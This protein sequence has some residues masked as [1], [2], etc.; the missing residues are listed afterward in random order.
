MSND[1]APHSHVPTMQTALIGELN[2]MLT[3]QVTACPEQER[4]RQVRVLTDVEWA[5][6]FAAVRSELSTRQGSF[7]PVMTTRLAELLGAFGIALPGADPH[8]AGLS[9][10][11]PP[12]TDADLHRAYAGA[13]RTLRTAFG[14]PV[15]RLQAAC[16]VLDRILAAAGVQVP[17][18][19]P[20]LHLLQ[21]MLDQRP[22]D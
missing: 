1:S 20:P 19:T 10:P 22:G 14:E 7:G 18:G 21:D 3:V 6:A 9:L 5:S 15:L 2:T 16:G 12:R 17:S 4:V 8:L 13:L 11:C